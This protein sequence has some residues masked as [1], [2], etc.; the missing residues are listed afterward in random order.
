MNTD[1]FTHDQGTFEAL[2]L[3]VRFRFKSPSSI[4]FRLSTK[5]AAY[6]VIGEMQVHHPCEG[7][8]KARVYIQLPNEYN[9]YKKLVPILEATFRELEIPL[10]ETY[11]LFFGNSEDGLIVGQTRNRK[12]IDNGIGSEIRKKL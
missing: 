1:K 3:R 12:G 4:G 11:E 8:I 6:T 10:D 5:Q 2:D 9:D 7:H